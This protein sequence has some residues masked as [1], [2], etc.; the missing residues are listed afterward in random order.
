MTLIN[1]K[2]LLCFIIALAISISISPA[3]KTKIKMATLAPEGTEWHGLLM[4]MGQEWKEATLGQVNLRV[5]PG[6]VVGDERDMIRKMRIGQIQGAAITSEGLTEIN[7]QYSV[8]FVPMLYQNFYLENINWIGFATKQ[9][10][11]DVDFPIYSGL[12]SPALKNGE[13]LEKA[14]KISKDNGAKGISIFT[15]DGLNKEQQAVF[16]KLKN[17]L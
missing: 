7:P 1:M 17:K 3:K 14:I 13:Q 2:R 10:V 5:Y 15:A 11:N 12:Y 4:K 8:F 16:V 9:G 6:G